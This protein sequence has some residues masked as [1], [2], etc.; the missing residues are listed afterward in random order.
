MIEKLFFPL[1]VLGLLLGTS[2]G[3]VA[4][5]GADGLDRVEQTLVAPP[6]LPK[7]S[8]VATGKPKVVKVRMVVKE[9][10]IKISSDVTV[11]AMTFNGT[12]PGPMIVVHQGDYVELTLVNPTGNTFLHN[13]DFHASTGAMGGGELTKLNPGQEVVLRFKAD[14]QGVFVYH[15]APGGAMIPFHVVSG[16]NG[17]LMVLPRDG[18]KDRDGKPLR[19]DKAFYIGEQDFYIPKNSDGSFKK[20]NSVPEAMGGTME[21]MRGLIPSHVVFNGAGKSV[22]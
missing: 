21:V 16:M 7:H 9:V 3:A 2:T 17:A 11:Q 20:F 12:I 1:L 8:Q 5:T 14:R 13:I 6:F 18:L 10:P 4:Q 15:C 19:Y 22:V